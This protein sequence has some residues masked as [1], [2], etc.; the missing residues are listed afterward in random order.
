MF[1]SI[2]LQN[3]ITDKCFSLYK[4]IAQKTAQ[5]QTFAKWSLDLYRALENQKQQFSLFFETPRNIENAYQN[6]CREIKERYIYEKKIF[7]IGKKLDRI[8]TKLREEEIPRRRKFISQYGQFIPR[9]FLPFLAKEIFVFDVQIPDTVLPALDRFDL[10][11][12]GNATEYHILTTDECIFVI[13]PVV[14]SKKFHF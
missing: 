3:M 14:R 2:C 4:S 1:F 9:S 7:G 6:A 11:E 10:D 8:L 13:W 12:T 5:S